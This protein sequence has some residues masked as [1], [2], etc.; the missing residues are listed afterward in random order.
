MIKFG[1]LAFG[2]LLGQKINVVHSRGNQQNACSRN[3]RHRSPDDSIF[4][5]LCWRPF[6][7]SHSHFGDAV[8][9]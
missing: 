2:Q 9:N 6:A 4:R 3:G 5:V 1:A 7:E 8:E